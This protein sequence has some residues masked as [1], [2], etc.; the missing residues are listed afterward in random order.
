MKNI[1]LILKNIKYYFNYN[2]SVFLLFVIGI[3]SNTILLIFFYGNLNPIKKSFVGDSSYEKQ[4]TFQFKSAVDE[5]EVE[6]FIKSQIKL[7]KVVYS[8]NYNGLNLM[9]KTQKID[10]SGYN[11]GCVNIGQQISGVKLNGRNEFTKT[12][13]ENAENVVIISESLSNKLGQDIKHGEDILKMGDTDY[14]IIGSIISGDSSILIPNTTYLKNGFETTRLRVVALK[15]PSYYDN[16]E[17]IDKV[18]SEFSSFDRVL[19][20]PYS[21]YEMLKSGTPVIFAILTIVFI[22]MSTTFIFLLKHLADNMNYVSIIQ[23]ICGA[24]KETV[25]FI[26]LMTIFCIT[27]GSSIIAILFHALS[28]D[29]I[30]KKLNTVEN[31]IYSFSDYLLIIAVI[32][33]ASIV[34][35]IPFLKGFIKDTLI[36]NKIKFS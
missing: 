20:H 18:S 5:N 26:K 25:V 23:S 12:E 17:I 33:L 10:S 13:I 29:I 11:V 28:Y 3:I 7:E 4:Y 16:F 35:T 9:F 15:K 34:S 6:S 14:K 21:D 30:L 32:S 1:L 8:T 31:L 36:S 19:N 24:T 2:K 27:L 22:A